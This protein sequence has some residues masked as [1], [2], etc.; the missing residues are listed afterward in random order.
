VGGDD[1]RVFILSAKH[2]LVR[3]STRLEPYDVRLGG[4]GCVEWSTIERQAQAFGITSAEVLF[5]GG[6]QYFTVCCY[7][8]PQRVTQVL[9]GLGGI[10][11]QLA[12][13]RERGFLSGLA[14]APLAAVQAAATPLS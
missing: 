11:K 10:G 9:A 7:V 1:S 6:R 5:F 8:W 4:F 14:P 12:W 13:L 2:G 3:P